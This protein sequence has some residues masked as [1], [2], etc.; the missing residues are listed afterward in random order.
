MAV[1]SSESTTESTTGVIEEAS[2]VEIECEN[3][4]LVRKSPILGETKDDLVQ[5]PE[6][7]PK[8]AFS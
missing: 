2:V 3:E 1:P 5:S 6:T 7:M 4:D 8:A